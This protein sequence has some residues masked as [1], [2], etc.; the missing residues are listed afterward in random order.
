MR[1]YHIQDPSTYTK[2]NKL[3]GSIRHLA[4]RLAL[5]DPQDPVRRKH[6]DML[7]E[8]LF[9]MGILPQK[10]KMSDVE[11]KVT[12]AAFCRRRLAVVMTRLR[13][14]ENV[15]AVRI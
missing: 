12:V 3:C 6:E 11:N 2:Y 14:C 9:G 5:L 1:R 10:S 13:M 8:K 4:H 15:P 7:L